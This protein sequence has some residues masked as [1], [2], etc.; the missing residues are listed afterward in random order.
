MQVNPYDGLYVVMEKPDEEPVP[1]ET[2]SIEAEKQRL[3]V[4]LLMEAKKRHRL[5][6]PKEEKPKKAEGEEEE[7][8]KEPPIPDLDADAVFYISKGAMGAWMML[9]PPNGKGEALSYE[10]L[11]EALEAESIVYG[12]DEKK[13]EELAR[14][15]V[16]FELILVAR[17]LPAV[18]GEDG[19]VEEKYPRELEG[20]FGVDAYGNVDYHSKVNMQIVK[21][22]DVLCEAFPPT[23]GVAGMKV[24]GTEIPA[25]DGKPPKLLG[26]VNTKFNEEKDKLLA[27]MEGNL[28]YRSERF[29]VQ[30]L[31]QVAGDVDYAIGNIDFTGDVHV[32]GDVKSGFVVRAKGNILVDGLVEGAILEAGGNIAIRKGV[33]GDDRAVIRSQQSVSA[34]YL[35]NCI[36]YAGDKV[37]TSSVIT[38]SIYSDNAIIVRSGRGTIIGGKL[39][40]TNT[41]S[42]TVI[43]CRSER[44]TELVIG[45]YPMLKQ[46]KEELQ[47]NMKE[48]VKEEETTDRNIRYLDVEGLVEDEARARE[49]ASVLAKLR[50]QKSVL[51]MRKERL[52]KQIDELEQ[53]EV[54]IEKCKVICDTVYP[55]TKIHIGTHA[56]N[57]DQLTYRCNIHLK[58]EEVLIY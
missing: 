40:A 18:P 7:I 44:M 51:G 3:G 13:I 8:K 34:Q 54:N 36:V 26:G 29:A 31:F 23:M 50:L 21:E 4:K 32:M 45:E 19:W 28:V 10:D 1:M 52:Q 58:D 20:T 22:N 46:Q 11:I 38:S 56:C 33:L 9:F 39:M 37:E 42:A 55:V 49:R 30:P 43:G 6:H 12:V 25:K 48:V 16:Y 17:G 27:A 15:P 41:I 35:E 53:K 2:A 14:N 47:V 57:I 5:V 24:T